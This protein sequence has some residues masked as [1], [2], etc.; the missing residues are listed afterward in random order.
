MGSST[1]N[2][3]LSDLC[4]RLIC[5]WAACSTAPVFVSFKLWQF[6]VS[7]SCHNAITSQAVLASNLKRKQAL[8][9]GVTKAWATFSN[10][11][12]VI[13]TGL[14]ASSSLLHSYS[15][16]GSQLGPAT[17]TST[18]R[19]ALFLQNRAYVSPNT[20]Y[21]MASTLHA[22]GFKVNFLNQVSF[23]EIPSIKLKNYY[24]ESS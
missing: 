9:A 15:F 2:P 3:L 13:L 10:G 1:S 11:D 8:H 12:S 20:E 4:R 24:Q 19:K 14:Q 17:T 21:H 22:W 16:I 7:L 5:E 6:L 18:V 23:W